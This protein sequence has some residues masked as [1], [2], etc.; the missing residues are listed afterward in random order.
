MGTIKTHFRFKAMLYGGKEVWGMDGDES[1]RVPTILKEILVDWRRK[2][3]VDDGH[4]LDKN[5]YRQ[6]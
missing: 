4:F 6:P 5:V 1:S 3:I 2:L